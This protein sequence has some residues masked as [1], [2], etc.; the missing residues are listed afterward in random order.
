MSES[1][2]MADNVIPQSNAKRRYNGKPKRGARKGAGSSSSGKA[3]GSSRVGA[4]SSGPNI[5]ATV[6][7]EADKG[8]LSS[9]P[10]PGVASEKKETTRSIPSGLA[11]EQGKNDEHRGS[12]RASEGRVVASATA[13]KASPKGAKGKGKAKSGKKYTSLRLDSTQ[14][15]P[16]TADYGPLLNPRHGRRANAAAKPIALAQA[17]PEEFS[18]DH[19][20]TL[21]SA[22]PVERGKHTAAKPSEWAPRPNPE[23]DE[24]ERLALLKVEQQKAEEEGRLLWLNDP[25]NPING[26]PTPAAIADGMPASVFKAPYVFDENWKFGKPYVKQKSKLF[27]L[28]TES[29]S[30]IFYQLDRRS[31]QKFARTSRASSA[32]VG[33]LLTVWDISSGDFCDAE[34]GPIGYGSPT[35]ITIITEFRGSPDKHKVMHEIRVLKAMTLA[36]SHWSPTFRILEFYR[37]P[38]VTAKILCIVLRSLPN[39][40]YLGVFGCDLVNVGDSVT[41]LESLRNNVQLDF[42]PRRAPVCLDVNIPTRIALPALLF[43]VLPLAKKKNSRLIGQGSAFLEF[44]RT[45]LPNIEPGQYKKIEAGIQDVELTTIISSHKEYRRNITIDPNSNNGRLWKCTYCNIRLRG[46]FFAKA[47]FK[48][49]DCLVCWGCKLKMALEDEKS[50]RNQEGHCHR[51]VDR[52]LGN[53]CRLVEAVENIHQGCEIQDE[54]QTFVG[55]QED[56][57]RAKMV[58]KKF[59]NPKYY[60]EAQAAWERGENPNDWWPEK[61]A[62]MRA[63]N[64]KKGRGTGRR[65]GGW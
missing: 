52:W 59:W 31:R 22:G 64:H 50:D 63:V 53:S 57:K 41:L 29:L 24:A 27:K 42:F 47:Q 38:L 14:V 21:G 5:K 2:T 16:P 40:E 26:G 8:G 32:L 7:K 45:V 56:D 28:A 58:R 33:M 3:N 11:G 37:A 17:L 13:E 60:R 4:P 15:S 23:R 44:L 34:K 20:P 19:F 48:E 12:P 55:L 9:P 1:I 30:A 46:C 10:G 36:I 35:E 39:L 51:Q 25:L 54:G 61:R 65:R 62:E 18:E 6:T 49:L 43:V